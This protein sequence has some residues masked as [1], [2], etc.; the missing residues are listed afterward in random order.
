LIE[1]LCINP[2]KVFRKEVAG[3]RENEKAI[4]TLFAPKQK[5]TVTESNLRSRSRNS[6]F[7]GKELT[8]KV[9]GI[10]NKEKLFLNQ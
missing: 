3:V 10:M 4:L 7:V 6:P 9:I 2:R 1:L 8:G 5:W